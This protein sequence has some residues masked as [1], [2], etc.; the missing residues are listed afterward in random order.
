MIWQVFVEHM[1]LRSPRGLIST[2]ALFSIHIQSVHHTRGSSRV[3]Q[4]Y[5]DVKDRELP[6]TLPRSIGRLDGAGPMTPDIK[7]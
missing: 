4:E 1:V 7:R 6:T 2:S 3:L 5:I